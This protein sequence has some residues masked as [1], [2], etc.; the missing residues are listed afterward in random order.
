MSVENEKQVSELQSEMQ[1][2][3]ATMA[4]LE[5]QTRK[6]ELRAEDAERS[7]R[8]CNLTLVCP[9]VLWQD[10]PMDPPPPPKTISAKLLY[11]RDRDD[12]SGCAEVEIP[13][14]I[15]MSSGLSQDKPHLFSNNSRPLVGGRRKVEGGG[16]PIYA[17]VPG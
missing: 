9:N 10:E 8:R 15:I 12:Y 3:K 13:P 1:S 11:Y 16:S 2:L 14:L 4:V 5:T 6:M 7:A 17:I